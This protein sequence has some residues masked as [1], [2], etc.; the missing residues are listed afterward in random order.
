MES[1]MIRQSGS[2]N[3]A[4]KKIIRYSDSKGYQLGGPYFLYTMLRV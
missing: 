1:T 4:R 2:V 3:F